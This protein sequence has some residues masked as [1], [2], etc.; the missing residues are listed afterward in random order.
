M[1]AELPYWCLRLYLAVFA[2]LAPDDEHIRSEH[3]LIEYSIRERTGELRSAGRSRVGAAVRA[4]W[5]H[6]GEVAP[7]ILVAKTIDDIRVARRRAL[8]VPRRSFLTRLAFA[9]VVTLLV[10]VSIFN[11]TRPSTT[12][13]TGMVETDAPGGIRETGEFGSLREALFHT[14]GICLDEAIEPADLTDELLRNGSPGA[15]CDDL[16]PGASGA[17]PLSD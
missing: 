7:W 3:A 8:P 4:W 10:G 6:L 11:A 16:R 9:G 13:G 12:F 15:N 1:L 14:Q 17:I 5:E 2:Y